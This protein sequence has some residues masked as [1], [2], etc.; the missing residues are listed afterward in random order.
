MYLIILLIVFAFLFYASVTFRL[1][2]KN[3]HLVAAYGFTD[4][5]QCVNLREKKKN[6]S[7]YLMYIE[8]RIRDKSNESS[9]F[10]FNSITIFSFAN[11][12]LSILSYEPSFKI[13]LLTYLIQL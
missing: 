6:G 13:N 2:V 4:I 1:I 5:L 10:S 7:S 3:P 8:I 11:S 9:S 12:F